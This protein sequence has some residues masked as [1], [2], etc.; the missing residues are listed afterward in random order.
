[1]IAFCLQQ[2]KAHLKV[3]LR[4]D[5]SR[6]EAAMGNACHLVQQTMISRH[7]K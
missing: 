1:M 2:G 5:G 7:L 4:Q 6:C 3:A